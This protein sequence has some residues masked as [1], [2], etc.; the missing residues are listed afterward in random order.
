MQSLNKKGLSEVVQTSLLILLSISAIFTMWSYVKDLTGDFEE[1]LSPVVGCINMKSKIESACINENRQV[2]VTLIK[3]LGEEITRTDF[4]LNGE[5]FICGDNLCQSCT[6]TEDKN[7]Q[8]I[9]LNPENE[10]LENNNLMVSI[11]GCNP[12]QFIINPCA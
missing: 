2:E 11:N 10:D 3:A 1:T 5:S 8:T 12:Q 7:L 9:Y 4:G 6:F